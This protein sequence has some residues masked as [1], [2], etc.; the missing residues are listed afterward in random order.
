MLQMVT[1][2]RSPH[3]M[4]REQALDLTVG[5]VMMSRP[6]TFPADATV[7]E[8]RR[9]FEDTSQRVALLVDGTTFR[10][11]ITR[12]Q[13]DPDA[14]EAESAIRYATTHVRSTTPSASVADAVDLLDLSHE[15]R[16]I[17]LDEDGRT[18]RG[19][20]CFNRSSASFCVRPS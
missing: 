20:L 10:G 16:L 14:R 12:S 11:S 18:L 4:P 5:E 2:E 13:L 1:G 3:R 8:I 6:K 15:A 7:G 19:L 17:V 9:A